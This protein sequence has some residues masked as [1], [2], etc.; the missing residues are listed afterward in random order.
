MTNTAENN[1]RIAKNTLLLYFR[2]MLTMAVSLYTSRV[3][4]NTLGVEDFGVY[5]VIGGVVAMLGFLTGSLS[6]ASSRYITYA[7]GEGN[8]KNLQKTFANIQA[9]HLLF[10]LFVIILAETIGLWFLNNYIQVPS[11]RE[12]AAFWVFQFSI[13][14]TSL[15]LISV[16]YNA[17]IIA[18]EKMEAFA[19]ISI[20]DVSLKLL[21]V[22]LLQ[23]ISFDKL[24]LYAAFLCGV[25]AIIQITYIFYCK[26]HFK[27]TLTLPKID[28]KQFKEIVVFAGWTMNGNLAVMGFTQ[29]LN[30]LLNIFFGPAVNAARGIAV[31]VQGVIQNFCVNFQVALNPQLTKSYAQQ[32]F[33]HM[34]QLLNVSSKFSFFLLLFISLPACL[35]AELVLKW[36]LGIVPEHTVTFLRLILFSSLLNALS[37]PII[38]SV[39]A[40]GKLKKFQLIEG[41]MLLFIVPIAY[42]GLKFFHY[43]AEYVF[44]VHILV[45]I[46]TQYARLRIVLPM[47]KMQLDYY[48]KEVIF[49]ILKVILIAPTIP[50]IAYIYT[51]KNVITFFFICTLCIIFN[52]IIIYFLG[53]TTN[54]QNFIKNKLQHFYTK[55]SNESIS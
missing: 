6:A 11:G 34:H 30:I 46:L 19:Y 55:K 5:N 54:E 28:K 37:N 49:P 9:I 23:I 35:E 41:I 31:Q 52:I 7:L 22:F 51:E 40:T 27:E 10:A 33:T 12:N 8:F 4:L 29:G 18:H 20:L 48:I 16:P 14:T 38:V 24:I 17:S 32:D 45:E 15:S 13:I 47:I 50:I 25:Q 21:I 39:H 42:I 36:W 26:R 43:P 53:C 3:V 44:I 2:M 1:K